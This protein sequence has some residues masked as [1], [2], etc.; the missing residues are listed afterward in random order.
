MQ[1]LD[2]LVEFEN[3]TLRDIGV[4]GIEY[5][6]TNVLELLIDL[7]HKVMRQGRSFQDLLSVGDD[8]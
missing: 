6:R 7:A 5:N 3:G 1:K 8:E 4:L 2:E